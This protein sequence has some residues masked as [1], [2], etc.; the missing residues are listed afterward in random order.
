MD[1]LLIVSFGL[2]QI[3]DGAITYLGL[4][5]AD[6]DEANPLASFCFETF[7]LGTSIATMKLLGLAFLAFVFV[8]RHR[9]R[10]PWV[11]ATLCCVVATYCWVVGQNLSLVLAT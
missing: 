3:A 10:S 2:L 7:G 6:I 11:T 1:G 9:I 4:H 8:R 5:C